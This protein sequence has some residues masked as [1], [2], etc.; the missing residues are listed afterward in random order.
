MCAAVAA[1]QTGI[2]AVAISLTGIAVPCGSCRQFLYEFNPETVV[3]LDDLTCPEENLP[4][5]VR[6][7]ELL[8][9]GFRLKQ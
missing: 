4:T 8:P 6:L 5:C 1:G 3:L 2:Q 9:K 7:S